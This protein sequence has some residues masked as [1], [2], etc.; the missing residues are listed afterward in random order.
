VTASLI[1]CAAGLGLMLSPILGYAPGGVFTMLK[2]LDE[3]DLDSDPVAQFRRWFDEAIQ[4]GQPEPTAMTLAT[5]TPDGTPAARMMLLKDVGPEGFVFY[6]NY[7]SA[8]GGQLETNP[9]G[10]LVFWWEKLRRQVRVEGSIEK[11]PAQLSDAYFGSRPRGSRLGAVASPQSSTIAGRDELEHSFAR[12]KEQYRGGPVPRPEH[13]GGYRLIPS[14]IEFWQQRPDRLH[15]R[16][17]YRREE[18]RWFIERL[19]P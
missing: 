14:R 9:R 12:A 8:K 11:L 1:L 6:T 10:A 13:W 5:A 19:A 15:D 7:N 18:G 2:G 17:R 4:T 3:R 16:L